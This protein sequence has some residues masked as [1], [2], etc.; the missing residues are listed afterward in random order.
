MPAHLLHQHIQAA[1]QIGGIRQKT[2][3]KGDEGTVISK[4]LLL[5]HLLRR[6]FLINLYIHIFHALVID[7]K[8]NFVVDTM[9]HRLAAADQRLPQVTGRPGQMVNAQGHSA[10]Q[11][12]PAAEISVLQLPLHLAAVFFQ[13]PG[14]LPLHKGHQHI[15]AK[16]AEKDILGQLKTALQQ[17]RLVLQHRHGKS[18]TVF[19][20]QF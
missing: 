18:E 6:H 15:L 14:I 13:L 3:R 1:V 5:R 17:N 4:Q 12:L 19:F 11:F 10:A 16:T 7:N 8:G 2:Y 20:C 9:S